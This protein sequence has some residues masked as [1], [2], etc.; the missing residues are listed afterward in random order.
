MYGRFRSGTVRK[1]YIFRT[2]K[3]GLK[4]KMN[5]GF[6]VSKSHGDSLERIARRTLAITPHVQSVSARP[7]NRYINRIN[8]IQ[9]R[10]SGSRHG[11]FFFLNTSTCYILCDF[12]S[13]FSAQSCWYR[14]ITDDSFSTYKVI[15]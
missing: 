2:K 6:N 13:P 12:L 15:F 5:P 1:V 9:I 7:E 14:D 10:N 4:E 11:V 3:T 8:K